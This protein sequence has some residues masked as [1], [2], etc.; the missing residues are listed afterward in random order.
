MWV[1]LC[2]PFLEEEILSKIKAHK[3]CIIEAKLTMETTRSKSLYAVCKVHF[4][5]Q[6]IIHAQFH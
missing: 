6:S 3:L 4:S 1:S 2:W 5:Y